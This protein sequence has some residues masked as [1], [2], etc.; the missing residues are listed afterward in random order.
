MQ[1]Y[2]S[3]VFLFA[4]SVVLFDGLT[5][6]CFLYFC[7]QLQAVMCLISSKGTKGKEFLLVCFLIAKFMLLEIACTYMLYMLCCERDL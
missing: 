2:I 1:N 7:I 4:C 6:I 3:P 5:Y